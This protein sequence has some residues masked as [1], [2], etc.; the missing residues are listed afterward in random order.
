M[1]KIKVSAELKGLDKK[2]PTA[3]S[4]E[5]LAAIQKNDTND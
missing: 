3:H 4:R 2:S 5:P 1:N